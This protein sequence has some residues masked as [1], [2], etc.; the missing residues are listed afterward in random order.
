MKFCKDSGWVCEDHPGRPWDGP[1]AC[2][3]GA[4]GVPCPWCNVPAPGET[5]RLPDG[6]KTEPARTAGA[7][8]LVNA[9]GRRLL[10]RRLKSRGLQP[11]ANM[12][13]SLGLPG[14]ADHFIASGTRWK[15]FGFSSQALCFFGKSFFK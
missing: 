2:P 8:E 4:A 1:H 3:C 14:P 9:W 13:S 10:F 15:Q 11:F 12:G 6:F 5:R 7:I